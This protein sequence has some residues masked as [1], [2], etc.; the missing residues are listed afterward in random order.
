MLLKEALNFI[1]ER[2]GVPA[3]LDPVL[4][5]K[6]THDVA[7]SELCQEL[8]RFF[9]M[10]LW[11]GP[12]LPGVQNCLRTK[13][14]EPRRYEGCSQ[15]LHDFAHQQDYQGGNRLKQ[16]KAVDVFMMERIL[17]FLKI[18]SFKDKMLVQDV[19]LHLNIASQLV[20]GEELLPAMKVPR[21]LFTELCSSNQ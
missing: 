12:N 13:K 20:K 7:V 11:I 1:K 4:V 3:V 19:P 8:I 5:C 21:P 2:E 6:E 15:K 17:P 9:L 10:Y 16:D 18:Q 14:I